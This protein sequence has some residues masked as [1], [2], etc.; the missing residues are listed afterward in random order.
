MAGATG[1]KCDMDRDGSF[2]VF[3]FG[4][5][6]EFTLQRGNGVPRPTGKQTQLGQSDIVWQKALASGS[7]L[8]VSAVDNRELFHALHE[9]RGAG[10]RFSIIFRTIKTFIPIDPVVGAEVNSPK[11]R[12]V[13]KAEVAAGV[14]RPKLGDAEPRSKSKAGS[15]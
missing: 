14:V 3:S 1:S 6:R 15:T 11:Y 9:Q 2:F 13:S 7:L 5:P 10:E 12:F 4:F 8:K